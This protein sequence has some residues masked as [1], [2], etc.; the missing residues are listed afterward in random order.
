MRC[1]KLGKTG[2][3]VSEL[4][5]GTWGLSGDGYG[6]VQEYEARAVIQRALAMG[7]TLFETADSYGKGNMEKLLGETLVG[8]ELVVVTKW[9]S[10]WGHSPPKKNFDPAYL[11]SCAEASRGRLGDKAKIIALLHNPSQL[12]MDRGEATETLKKLCAEGLIASWG[13]SAGSHGV[14]QAALVAEAPVVSFSYNVLQ[15]QPL[16]ALSKTLEEQETGVLAHSILFYGLLTGRWS[17]NKSFRNLDHRFDR[18]PP[19]ALRSRVRHLDALRPLVS[20]DVL[21]LRAAAVRFV[22]SNP[23]ISSAILGP[24]SGLQLDQLVR[25]NRGEPPYLSEPKLSALESR[26]I[27]LEVER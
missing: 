23:L 7:I 6:P 18:W 27:H 1:R 8:E 11:R 9:G 21:S 2:L 15:V 24:H 26:L 20:G 5:L 13:V 3:M 25:E 19:G 12:T 14:A 17:P 4:S 22:L 10:D 16:R